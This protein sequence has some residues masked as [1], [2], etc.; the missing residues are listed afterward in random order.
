[1]EIRTFTCSFERLNSRDEIKPEL[2]PLIDACMEAMKH[3]YA[4]YSGFSVGAALLL[5]NGAIV[6]GNI[7]KTLPT[8]VVYAPSA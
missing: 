7:R 2:Q 4:P 3:A 6:K 8:L 5:E 1:M